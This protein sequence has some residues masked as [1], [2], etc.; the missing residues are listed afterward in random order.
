MITNSAKW[1]HPGGN[2]VVPSPWQATMVV[3][4][5]ESHWRGIC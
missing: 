5:V 2:P 4:S 1:P 3:A